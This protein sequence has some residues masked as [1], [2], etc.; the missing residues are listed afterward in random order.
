MKK[1]HAFIIV[2]LILAIAMLLLSSCMPNSHNNSSPPIISETSVVDM[3]KGSDKIDVEEKEMEL[4]SFENELI[5]KSIFLTDKMIKAG[6]NDAYIRFF[7]TTSIELFTIIKRNIEIGDMLPDRAIILSFDNSAMNV[8]LDEMAGD[9]YS[10]TSTS[11]EL[12]R[13]RVLQSFANTISNKYG[14]ES[15]FGSTVVLAASSILRQIE[16]FQKPSDPEF[17]GYSLVI[18]LYPHDYDET[19]VSFISFINSEEETILAT[20]SFVLYPSEIFTVLYD[21]MEYV[22]NSLREEFELPIPE[23][24]V[25]CTIYEGNPLQSIS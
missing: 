15:I 1:I 2:A 9:D 20:A 24:A 13:E 17:T 7:D 12:L 5:Q 3:A 21:D 25:D 19:T 4:V 11:R 16:A 22:L 8:M 6:N 14:D 10:L 23:N 18:L